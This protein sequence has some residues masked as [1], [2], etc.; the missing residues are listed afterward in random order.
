MTWSKV[1]PLIGASQSSQHLHF[2]LAKQH[3]HR[4]FWWMIQNTRQSAISLHCFRFRLN[5]QDQLE[6]YDSTSW[7]HSC[8]TLYTFTLHIQRLSELTA[9]SWCVWLCCL[10]FLDRTSF[11]I[12]RTGGEA[13]TLKRT[14][15]NTVASPTEP[16]KM[17][18]GSGWHDL[19][20]I[21][22]QIYIEV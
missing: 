18:S 1:A 12:P 19:L 17:R 21:L 22:K 13:G 9:S 3:I 16:K 2:A 15:A 4:S 5:A 20:A 6:F 8:H 11:I 7:Q 10:W 14:H